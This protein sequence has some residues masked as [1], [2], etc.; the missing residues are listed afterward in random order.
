MSVIPRALFF[1]VSPF[2]GPPFHFLLLFSWSYQALHNCLPPKSPLFLTMPLGVNFSLFVPNR[3]DLLRQQGRAP[4]VLR[5]CRFSCIESVAL[6]QSF[7]DGG[8][9]LC[10]LPL[11]VDSL[12]YE[13]AGVGVLRAPVYSDFALGTWVAL[14]HKW[15]LNGQR[16][17]SPFSSTC[18]ELCFHNT[19][20]GVE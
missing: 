17:R 19:W 10:R 7:G 18:Q 12:P 11:L 1:G 14:L 4:C 20:L 2:L 13:W 6:S 8:S 15:E 3:V 5:A 9:G 16:R